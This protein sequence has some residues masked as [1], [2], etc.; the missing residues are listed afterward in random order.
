MT[1]CEAVVA[2][3]TDK[4]WTLNIKIQTEHWSEKYR[5]KMNSENKVWGDMENIKL[6]VAQSFP[7]E[8][9]LD[10]K[11]NNCQ[12]MNLMTHDLIAEILFWD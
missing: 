9:S 10:E 3:V 7:S 8:V 12:M 11:N 5:K 2:V 6:S 4:L 1:N